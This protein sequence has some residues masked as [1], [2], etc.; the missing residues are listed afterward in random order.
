MAATPLANMP[1]ARPRV[2]LSRWQ[3]GEIALGTHFARAGAAQIAVVNQL[4][5]ASAAAKRRWKMIFIAGAAVKF[6]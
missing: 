6:R 2:D 4:T 5:G 3:I 1:R